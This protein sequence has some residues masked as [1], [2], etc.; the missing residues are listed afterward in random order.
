MIAGDV[1][2]ALPAATARARERAASGRSRGSTSAR[3]RATAR[4][5]ASQLSG[6][7][8]LCAVVKADGYGHG[9]RV[10]R[11][12]ALEGGATWLAVATAGEAEELRRHGV[13]GRI[14][15]MG[16]LTTEELRLALRGATPTSWPGDEGFV[17]RA[18]RARRAG[19][20]RGRACT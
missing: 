9:A 1:I 5:C 10:V 13:D 12:A 18:R 19:G 8:E 3:S 20:A 14:L 6:G 2:E 17:D 7:A 11:E 16:A 4:A 15:V